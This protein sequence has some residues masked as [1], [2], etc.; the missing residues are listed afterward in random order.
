VDGQW[1]QAE[2][3]AGYFF[4][5]VINYGYEGRQLVARENGKKGYSDDSLKKLIEQF[6]VPASANTTLNY[7]NAYNAPHWMQVFRSD[8]RTSTSMPGWYNTQMATTGGPT[9]RWA[10]SWVRDLMVAKGY[11]ISD[12]VQ[13]SAT[14]AQVA[15]A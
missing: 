10:T 6:S 5:K 7:L 13:P 11:L 4:Y 12:E 14:C 15:V 9:E 3:Y 1:G 2:S 8:Q